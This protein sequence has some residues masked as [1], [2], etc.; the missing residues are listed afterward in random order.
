MLDMIYSNKY[1]TLMSRSLE[2]IRLY[3]ISIRS[4]AKALL[5]MDSCKFNAG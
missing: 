1:N 2:E 4:A 5:Y 3:Y